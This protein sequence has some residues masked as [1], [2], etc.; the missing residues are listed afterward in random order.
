[1]LPPTAIQR[2]KDFFGGYSIFVRC[3]VCRHVREI[4]PKD[5]AARVGWEIDLATVASRLKC[6]RCGHK[7]VDVAVGFQR[8][9]RGWSSNPS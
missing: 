5:L 6:S 3:R 8:R 9:P 2:L 1:V 4:E 7:H